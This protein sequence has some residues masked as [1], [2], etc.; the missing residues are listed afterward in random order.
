MISE[1]KVREI[2]VDIARRRLESLPAAAAAKIAE[3][4]TVEGREAVLRK[5]IE[6]ALDGFEEEGWAVLEAMMKNASNKVQTK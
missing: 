4:T 2:A 6:Q 1:Q 5:A 3:C